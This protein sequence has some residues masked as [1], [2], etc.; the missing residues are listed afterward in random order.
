[1]LS[2]IFEIRLPLGNTHLDKE[3]MGQVEINPA[4]LYEQEKIYTSDL[5]TTPISQKEIGETGKEKEKTVM[6]IEDNE[7]LRQFL[8][9]KLSAEYEILEAYNGQSALQ[10]AYDNIPDIIV[11]DVVIPGQD[12]MALT[13]TL[14]ND[15]RS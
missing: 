1:L 13:N 12:G 6:I 9:N 14:K 11:C 10:L 3:E 7:D 8:A 15:I 2:G 5:Q 4:V